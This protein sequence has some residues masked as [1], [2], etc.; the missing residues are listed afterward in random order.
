[1]AAAAASQASRRMPRIT[2]TQIRQL[3]SEYMQTASSF[4]S[5]NFKEY[6]VR[7]AEH[8][9]D[10]ELPMILSGK[11]GDMLADDIP[12][13][14]METVLAWYQRAEKDLKQLKRSA[15]MN[16]MYE[17]PKLVVEGLGRMNATGGGGDGM[18]AGQGG[19]GQT[20]SPQIDLQ[21]R[22]SD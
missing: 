10:N 14:K 11:G 2:S 19:A 1:M 9:F 3:R 18:E 20:S 12:Q 5:Y 17:A 22:K 4:S 21:G 13:E 6:F 7:R 15:I 8:K 16:Q